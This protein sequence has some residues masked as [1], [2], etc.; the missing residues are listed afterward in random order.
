MSKIQLLKVF[1]NQ[2]LTAVAQEIFGAVEQTIA[3]YQEECSRTKEENHRLQKLLDVV[4]EPELKLYQADLHHLTG[5]GEQMPA[6]KQFIEKWGPLSLDKEDTELTQI[7]KPEEPGTSRVKEELPWQE[8]GVL[9]SVFVKN[10]CHQDLGLSSDLASTSTEQMHTEL[11]EDLQQHS[12]LGKVTCEKQR[13]EKWSPPSLRPED[14]ELIKNRQEE[15]GTSQT[16]AQIHWL[17]E[18]VL[19]PSQLPHLRQSVENQHGD[20]FST[21]GEQIKTERGTEDYTVPELNNYSQSLSAGHPKC[22][23]AQTDNSED[24]GLER[25]P[26]SPGSKIIHTV[27][28]KRSY[29]GANHDRKSMEMCCGKLPVGESQRQDVVRLCYCKKCTPSKTAIA[30]PKRTPEWHYFCVKLKVSPEVT[31][32]VW[33]IELSFSTT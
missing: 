7:N 18:S 16:N 1:L 10:N 24:P 11:D 19:S 26:H 12:D 2:R 5:S 22:S 3:D 8:E 32:L 15:L 23:A 17:E 33:S 28:D 30:E 25:G 29:I 13:C 4:I 21:T 27:Q 20:I 9:C 14:P 6:E 31:R